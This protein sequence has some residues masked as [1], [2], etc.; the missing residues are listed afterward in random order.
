MFI[1]GNVDDSMVTRRKRYVNFVQHMCFT[2][3]IEPKNAKEALLDKFWVKAMH[4]ELE[5]FS[6]NDV[7]TLMPRPNHTHVIGT[8]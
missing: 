8:K 4:E 5:Q 3:L 6:Q 2:S 7:W 1:I